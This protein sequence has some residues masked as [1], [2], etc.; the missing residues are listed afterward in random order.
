MT[1]YPQRLDISLQE[2]RCLI[3]QPLSAGTTIQCS[4]E[5]ISLL[6]HPEYEALSYV[7]GDASI[8]RTIVFNE[9]PFPVTQNL[10]IALHHL[11]LPDRP[12]RLWVDA[13]CINQ[14]DV[15]E[16]N[17]QVG[18]MG[19][20]YSLANPV[21]I[22]LG[23]SSEDSDEAFALMS[24]I[25]TASESDVTEEMSQIMFSFYIQLVEREWFTRLW[26]IQELV[27]ANQDPLVGCGFTW[28]T[29]S[30]LLKAWQKVAMIE[31]T[32]MGMIMKN[33]EAESKNENGD[34]VADSSNVRTS[35]I[36][37]DLLNNLRAAVTNKEGEDLRDLLLN[38]VSSKAT[39]PKDRIYALLGMMRLEDR[40]HLTVDYD[41]PL[42]TVYAEAISHIFQKGNGP[43]LLSGMELSGPTPPK[44]YSSFPSWVPRLGSPSLLHPTRFHPPGIGVSGAGSDAINGHISRDLKT[45]YIRGLPIDTII[46]KFT[47]G[48]N[49]E[50]L[51]QLPRAETLVRKALH[52]ATQHTHHRPHLHILKT[53]HPL[54]RTLITNK[55]YSGAART[56]APDS[57]GEMYAHLREQYNPTINSSVHLGENNVHDP[58][59]EYRLS[60]LNHLPNSTFFITATGF[61]GLGPRS[62]EIGDRLAIW[63][64]APAPF[65]LRS[66]RIPARNDQQR[67]AD[68]GEGEEEKQKQKKDAKEEEE[69]QEEISAVV[70]V[71]YVSGIMDGEMVDEVY[72]ED[73]EDDVMFTIR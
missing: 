33:D 45:L 53:H 4:V 13:L 59:R 21:L 72:C 1:H 30:M 18:L 50:C 27:L 61:H 38:T 9:I 26:T 66:R 24:E 17:E 47:F 19:E 64:G 68:S 58:A 10:S 12:R 29:W 32:N 31:F 41:R 57:Y 46:E 52:L 15:Q 7:W 23:E 51:R 14:G 56:V 60:L 54:W 8:Q 65:I 70:G 73:L 28:T 3:L 40:K 22:W 11:R 44:Q 67:D 36:K 37:I 39:E 20:I 35:A 49:Q 69:Q 63:F 71:A 34:S 16:R 62:V 42:G 5:I 2:I 43:F 6:S 48:P 55:T 25:A